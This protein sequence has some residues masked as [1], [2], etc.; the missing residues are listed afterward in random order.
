[1]A[2]AVRALLATKYRAQSA[3]VNVQE[4][5]LLLMASVQRSSA[6]TVKN[7]STVSARLNWSSVRRAK[8]FKMASVWRLI[9]QTVNSLSVV[10][11]RL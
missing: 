6:P 9:V 5:Y 11:A 3:S 7:Q 2:P 1:M 10:F 4:D 8:N